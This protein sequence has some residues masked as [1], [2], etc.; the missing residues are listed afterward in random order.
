MIRVPGAGVQVD[1]APDGSF[2]LDV[3]PGRYQVSVEATGFRSQRR[4]VRVE[5]DG[6]TILQ[7]DLRPRR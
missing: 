3:P 5:D 1:T 7:F 2:E 4:R 6:V